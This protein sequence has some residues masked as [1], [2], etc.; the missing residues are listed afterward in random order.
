MTIKRPGVYFDESV[1]Y[2]LEGSGGKIP[3]FIGV[4]G[5]TGTADYKV[6]GTQIQ[7]FKKW[8][9]VNMAFPSNELKV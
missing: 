9:E 4:T 1:E 3:V 8:S 6:D 5:N 2:E 7:K